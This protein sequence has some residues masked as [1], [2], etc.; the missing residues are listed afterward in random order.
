MNKEIEYG[1]LCTSNCDCNNFLKDIYCVV[2]V[3][4]KRS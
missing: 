4:L 1:V 3:I 2:E